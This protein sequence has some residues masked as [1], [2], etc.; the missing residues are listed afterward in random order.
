MAKLPDVTKLSAKDQKALDDLL[1]KAGTSLTA[2]TSNGK[3]PL[4]DPA[5]RK[6][7]LELRPQ[8]EAKAKEQ[9]VT[10]AHIFTASEKPTVSY[11]N[12]DTGGTY[13]G[14]GKKPSWLK[15]HQ[16]EYQIRAN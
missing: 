7:C 16:A 5:Y 13:S 12:P 8:F 1:A 11:R 3:S 4:S 2:L 10:L 14:R 9:G 15:G 6:K